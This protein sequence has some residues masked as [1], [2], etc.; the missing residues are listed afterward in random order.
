MHLLLKIL[1]TATVYIFIHGSTPCV[2]AYG[3]PG[4][5]TP[6]IAAELL[7]M[8]WSLSLVIALILL[9]YAF[10]R[11]RFAPINNQQG[12]KIKIIELRPLPGKKSLCLVEVGGKKLLLGIAENS[13]SSLA[14]FSE[15]T[16]FKSTLQHCQ[17]QQNRI[18]RQQ[19]QQEQP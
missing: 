12:K 10:F 7:Q 13:I 18:E 6:G 2:A 1:P 19:N 5:T 14:E 9:L 8:I 17:Q 3:E 16:S 4:K 15:E 11:K